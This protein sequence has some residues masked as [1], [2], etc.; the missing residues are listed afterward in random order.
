MIKII[1]SQG[2]S[3]RLANASLSEHDLGTNIF[4]RGKEYLYLCH[5]YISYQYNT[6]DTGFQC[7]IRFPLFCIDYQNY[8]S[9]HKCNDIEIHNKTN[10]T[11]KSDFAFDIDDE[12]PLSPAMIEQFDYVCA[13]LEHK[14]KLII[15]VDTRVTKQELLS[16]GHQFY[17][18]CHGPDKLCLFS[19]T[20]EIP[21]DEESLLAI[22]E[23]SM[24]QEGLKNAF[25][26]DYSYIIGERIRANVTADRVSTKSARQ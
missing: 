13:M 25:L 17:A 1:R 15:S 9:R 16:V 21:I 14:F 10:V 22:D 4:I 2:G 11:I 18:M 26:K 19:D 3:Y 7:E 8:Y 23:L 24:G 6:T 5:K 20:V 12:N